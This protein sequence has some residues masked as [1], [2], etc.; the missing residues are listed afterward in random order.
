MKI[1]LKILIITAFSFLAVS[2][3]DKNPARPQPL[4]PVPKPN[5]SVETAAFAVKKA[6]YFIRLAFDLADGYLYDNSVARKRYGTDSNYVNS[7][8]FDRA[9]DDGV[10]SSRDLG[11]FEFCYY[12]D[13]IS[14]PGIYDVLITSYALGGYS[15]SVT[16]RKLVVSAADA[17]GYP[18]KRFYIRFTGADT[19]ADTLLFDIWYSSTQYWST[20]NGAYISANTP[21][22]NFQIIDS[23]Q[24]PRNFTADFTDINGK[25]NGVYAG[26]GPGPGKEFIIQSGNLVVNGL[27][28]N[29]D[30]NYSDDNKAQGTFTGSGFSAKI[31]LNEDGN[32]GAY[33]IV[34]GS[35][36]IKHYIGWDFP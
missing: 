6:D 33:Y 3:G 22:I 23:S 7:L 20:R 4:P 24:T 19:G 1:I 9:Y 21:S 29:I 14:N 13:R 10:I 28:Y 31:Y 15:D 27:G 8:N 2:C 11:T 17:G 12:R 26:D 25:I 36:D 30:I 32:Y 34:D 18:A 16:K 35:T 5:T